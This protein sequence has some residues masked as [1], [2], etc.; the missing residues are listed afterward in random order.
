M[1]ETIKRLFVK[2]GNKTLVGNA[3]KKN[4]ITEDQFLVITGEAYK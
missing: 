3:V 4:W 2:T 1:F